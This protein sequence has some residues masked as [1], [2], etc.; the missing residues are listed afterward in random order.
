M[1]KIPE[2]LWNDYFA[3]ECA[4]IESEEERELTKK[5]IE[6]HEKLSEL[7]TKEQ[8][9]A[10]ERYADALCD[11]SSSFSKKAFF[12]GCEFMLSLVLELGIYGK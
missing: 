7:L 6:M 4:A 10:V 3:D 1:K 2:S 9:E 8:N 5:A 12:K 11:I